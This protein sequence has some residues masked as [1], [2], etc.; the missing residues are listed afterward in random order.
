MDAPRYWL[1]DYA[2]GQTFDSPESQIM[3]ADA[4]TSFAGAYDPQ[5][6]HTSAEAATDTFFGELVASGWHTGAVTMRLFT[7]IRPLPAWG[8]IGRGVETL[9][10]P[11]PVRPGDTLRLR[12]EV[13][14]VLPSRSKPTLGTVRMRLDTLNQDDAIVQT[15]TA[16][17]LVPRKEA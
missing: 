3:T 10:W 15:L 9:A 4:I 16:A 17:M 2:P 14:A 12:V 6:F 5:P 8:C 13:L 7:A 11:R 1:D